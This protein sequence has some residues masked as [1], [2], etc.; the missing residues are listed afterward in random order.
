[1]A[2][3]RL[4]LGLM[5][6]GH[7]VVFVVGTDGEAL[8][9]FQSK[10]I[11][12]HY[13]PTAYTGDGLGFRYR[14]HRNTLRRFL[15][16]EK[17]DIVH[18][19]DLPTHQMVSGA[20]KPLCI[21]RV[22]HHRWVFDGAETDWFNKFGAE[23]HV[24]VSNFSRE[25]IVTVSTSIDQRSAIVIPDGIP[26]EDCPSHSDCL[27]AKIDLGLS[28]DRIACLFVG[29]IAHHKGVEDII[30][31]WSIL[32]HDHP[33]LEQAADLIFVGEDLR[34]NGEY[35]QKMETKA[36]DMRVNARF[37][38]FQEEPRLWCRAADILLVPS[39]IEP[40]GLVTAEAM[41]EYTA[42]VGTKVGGIKE[43]C[44]HNETGLLV[45]PSHPD[46]LADAI[47]KLLEN[48]ELRRKFAAT[49][50]ERCEASFSIKK[51]TLEME[52]LF[53]CIKNRNL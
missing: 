52:K 51:H 50:R 1:M 6:S 11:R 3:E 7:Q 53:L 5:E 29:Q 13:I 27:Q 45:E 30:E 4:A 26:V 36:R 33:A 22:C 12:C 32:H 20:A 31:A 18:S 8:K 19:N 48:E 43:V 44:I 37:M 21:P 34:Q 49:G 40:F 9:R 47:Y 39:H 14:K 25:A 16:N 23:Q 10:S 2:G 15:V 41:A 28:V 46:Q 38:G 35:R 42:V 17:P 24:F